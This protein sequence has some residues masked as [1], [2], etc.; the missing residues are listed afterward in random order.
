MNPMPE[1]RNGVYILLG[2]ST[3]YSAGILALHAPLG[4]I[5]DRFC[6]KENA[7]MYCE[8][9]PIGKTARGHYKWAYIPMKNAPVRY[10]AHIPEKPGYDLVHP[11]TGNL[12][13]WHLKTSRFLPAWAVRIECEL[14]NV[15][16]QKIQ[17]ISEEDATQ[18]GVMQDIDGLCAIEEF[19]KLWDSIH[20]NNLSW[21]QNPVV[22]AYT[23]RRI[24]P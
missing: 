18:E 19:Q 3:G 8:R 11:E 24:E 4:R 15:R 13:L 21:N 12:W 22:F 20:P 14:T 10:R 2:D 17:H 1:Y 9:R 7:W 23:F 6:I 16:V 5:G